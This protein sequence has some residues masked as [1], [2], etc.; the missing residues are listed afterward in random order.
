MSIWSCKFVFCID[1]GV[2]P[3]R[4]LEMF[5]EKSFKLSGNV[6]IALGFNL[7]MRWMVFH[8]DLGFLD[9]E[10]SCKTELSQ[11]WFTFL[12][13]ISF[14]NSYT[15]QCC[16]VNNTIWCVIVLFQLSIF[17]L[18]RV[19][20]KVLVVV[21]VFFKGSCSSIHLTISW[22]KKLTC[23]SGSAI[24]YTRFNGNN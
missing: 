19:S 13:E 24:L 17:W 5:E 18:F 2:F 6:V 23:S 22:L 9:I 11:T 10:L 1:F 12:A 8:T 20:S 21:L 14:H 4:F 7:A 3:V 16:S 15:Y